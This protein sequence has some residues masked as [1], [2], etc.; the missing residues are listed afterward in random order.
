MVVNLRGIQGNVAYRWYQLAQGTTAGHSVEYQQFVDRFRADSGVPANTL[1]EDN[2]FYVDTVTEILYFKIAGAWTSVGGG[3][4]GGGSDL[5]ILDET[6]SLTTAATGLNFEGTGVSA[7]ID[8][9]DSGQVNITIPGN[10]DPTVTVEQTE[11]SRVQLTVNPGDSTSDVF[12]ATRTVAGVMS[13]ADKV[14][15]DDLETYDLTISS[16]STDR[17]IPTSLSFSDD[18]NSLTVSTDTGPLHIF[19]PTDPSTG[20]FAE[21][22][23][24]FSGLDAAGEDGASLTFSGGVVSNSK[25]VGIT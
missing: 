17:P 10:V 7:A 9:D 14:R 21:Q 24:P 18:G 16:G 13:A 3:G 4:G 6:T 2:E 11:A 15:L 25:L 19:T 20:D 5:E 12:A 23:I 8:A 1:G 22:T